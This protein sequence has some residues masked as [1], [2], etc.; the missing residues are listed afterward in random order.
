[1]PP[2]I[3]ATLRHSVSPMPRP[4]SAA[5]P[6]P[7]SCAKRSKMRSSASGAMPQPLSDTTLTTSP[8]S[9]RTCR[10]MSP[11]LSVYFAA[12]DSRFLQQLH[13]ACIVAD[14]LHRIVGHVQ[15][16]VVLACLHQRACGLGA[17]QRHV[18]EADAAPEH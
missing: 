16:E 3:S 10:R 15:R 6:A 9:T 13:E 5:A 11:P 1:M 12:L 2:C 14:E 17:A 7:S 4:L 8:S 18:A